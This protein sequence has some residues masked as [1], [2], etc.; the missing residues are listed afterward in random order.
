MR[1]EKYCL[2][3]KVVFHVYVQQPSMLDFQNFALS[4]CPL[5]CRDKQCCTVQLQVVESSL[6]YYCILL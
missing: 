4:L 5:I 3:M 1:E 2:P 6:F